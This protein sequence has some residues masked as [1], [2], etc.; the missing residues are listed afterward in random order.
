VEIKVIGG[1]LAHYQLIFD[2]NITN[3]LAEDFISLSFYRVDSLDTY[4]DSLYV[5]STEF[6]YAEA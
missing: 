5:T 3:L 4:S 2:V 6:R 1:D